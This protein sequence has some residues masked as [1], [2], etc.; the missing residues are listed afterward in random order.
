MA[1]GRHLEKLKNRHI[2]TAFDLWCLLADVV[3]D[4]RVRKIPRRMSG[5]LTP[6]RRTPLGRTP[7]ADAVYNLERQPDSH[8]AP[9]RRREH[10]REASLMDAVRRTPLRLTPY[11]IYKL[12]YGTA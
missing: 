4:R 9:G 1:D 7:Y 11:A 8:S 12:E 10:I 5:R 2:S 6:L 3:C